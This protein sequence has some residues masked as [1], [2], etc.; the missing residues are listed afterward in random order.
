[1][2][3]GFDSG[4]RLNPDSLEGR[5]EDSMAKL[6]NVDNIGR[7][8]LVAKQPKAFLESDELERLVSFLAQALVLVNRRYANEHT[9]EFA[10]RFVDIRNEYNLPVWKLEESD[11]EG[12]HHHMNVNIPYRLFIA[13][14][15][16]G[17][18]P[19]LKA[20]R[21]SSTPNEMVVFSDD[22]IHGTPRNSKNNG[23]PP[24]RLVILFEVISF[25]T[26]GHEAP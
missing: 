20:L 13:K 24:Y 1:M 23:R 16:L 15:E 8:V 2:L 14:S 9:G 22:A 18:G 10:L 12:L 19:F 26:N 17:P 21:R 5:I 3:F 25:E 11:R 6:T 4:R 7:F